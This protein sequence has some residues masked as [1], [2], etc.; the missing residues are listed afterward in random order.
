MKK[1]L[2]L[3]LLFL[4]LCFPVV[5]DAVAVSYVDKPRG[6]KCDSNGQNCEEW[7]T[8]IY[9]LN[10]YNYRLYCLDKGFNGPGRT[11]LKFYNGA[12]YNIKGVGPACAFIETGVSTSYWDYSTYNKKGNTSS[13]VK[14][15]YKIK[16]YVQ[17]NSLSKT[18]C[19]KYYYVSGSCNSKNQDAVDDGSK[20]DVVIG[21][22]SEK[23]DYSVA[24]VTITP[25]K[26]IKNY[27]IT[28]SGPDGTIIT[29]T[30]ATSDKTNYNSKTVSDTVMYVKVPRAKVDSKTSISVTAKATYDTKCTYKVPLIKTYYY[31]GY[32]TDGKLNSTGKKYFDSSTGVRKSGLT[33]KGY[34]RLAYF[35]TVT[36]SKTKTNTASDSYSRSLDPSLGDLLIT[37]VDSVNTNKKLDGVVFGLYSNSS[38]TSIYNNYNNIKTVNGSVGINNLEP[39]TYYLKE[40]STISGYQLDSNC[41]PVTVTA[42]STTKVTR[43]N[44]P[45]GSLTI[46]KTAYFSNA[47]VANAYFNLYSDKDCANVISANYEGVNINGVIHT[48]ADGIAVFDKLVAGNYYIKESA[49]PSGYARNETCIPVNVVK[50]DNTDVSVVNY[51]DLSLTI[52]KIGADNQPL[53][54]VKFRLCSD[55]ECKVLAKKIDGTTVGEL[56]TDENG[57][58]KFTNLKYGIYY[59]KEVEVPDGY[60]V[61]NTISRI[62]IDKNVTLNIKNT[63]IKLEV[64]K[65]SMNDA[66]TLLPGSQIRFVYLNGLNEETINDAPYTTLVTE[67]RISNISL[68]PGVY[69]VYEDYAPIG[70][71]NLQ[72]AFL[73]E[74]ADDGTFS[75]YTG[76]EYNDLL[77]YPV[78]EDSEFFELENNK[79]TIVNEPIYVRISKQDI[80]SFE[81]VEGATIII[82]DEN[83]KEVVKFISDGKT[84]N[85][86]YLEPGNYT[87]VEKVPP[88]GY[89]RIETKINFAI[90]SYGFIALE[91]EE[92]KMY[93]TDGNNTIILYNEIEIFEVPITGLSKNMILITL[94]VALVGGGVYLIYKRKKAY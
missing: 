41:A 33:S 72:E 59:Y 89:K 15:D 78:V 70:F 40:I 66:D 67:D 64:E 36:E 62:G 52:N 22:F 47:P 34:Q 91:D 35:T 82:Y 31:E 86:F 20:V 4:I 10:S 48:G 77:E 30:D 54:G 17:V 13:M 87:L 25:T 69:A 88:K 9:T 29:K 21:S 57:V 63:A 45:L 43:K 32:L 3:I 18:K 38:C 28:V 85:K 75:K 80:T 60:I 6:G 26:S 24:K 7:Y 44:N 2:F 46:H 12:S 39:G 42:G 84:S 51:Q 71:V 5:V 92:N 74:V 23:G 53:P 50:G 16:T 94:G 79:L 55:A 76:D 8:P 37:K 14:D 73:L 58:V 19:S 81:E 65:V 11:G 61:D 27:L 90:G 56:I 68:N 49:A 1:K 93:T 83:G